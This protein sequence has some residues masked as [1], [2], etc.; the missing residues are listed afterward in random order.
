MLNLS[1]KH[2]QHGNI[3]T[4]QLQ[5]IVDF[6]FVWGRV[7]RFRDVTSCSSVI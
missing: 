2:C 7:I 3:L 6:M 4:L 1:Y 5:N